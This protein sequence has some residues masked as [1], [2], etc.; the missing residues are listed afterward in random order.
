MSN[1]NYI[2]DTPLPL[3]QNF[4]EL[5]EEGLGF[6]QSTSG[7]AW[8][9]FN[10]SDPG[11]TI[12]DQMCYAL[13]ELGYCNDFSISDILTRPDGKLQME[14][15][16]YLP[17]IILTTSALTANDY[18]KLLIDGV[19]GVDNAIIISSSKAYPFANYVYETYL[20]IN[21]VISTD[22]Y[23]DICNSAYYCLNKSRNLGEQFLKP[24]PLT[25]K[26]FT[27]R[28]RLNIKSE[29]LLNATL[30]QI[31]NAIQNYIFPGITQ[32][33][34]SALKEK[35]IATNS[36]FNGPRLKNGWIL[37]DELGKKTDTLSSAGLVAVFNSVS[38]VLSVTGLCFNEAA[39]E[40]QI[41]VSAT[42][43]IVIDLMASVLSCKLEIYCNG[44]QVSE[45]QNAL[46]DQTTKA[47]QL[48]TTIAYGAWN[49]SQ[50]GLPKGK[51]RDIETYYSIQ[52]T[53]PEIF[54]VGADSVDSNAT[55]FE[56]AQSRQLK[57][58]LALTD[59][60]LANQFSQ[61]GNVD[62]LF[63]F[64]NT[65]T[66]IP[67]QIKSFYSTAGNYGNTYEEYPV[68]FLS[69]SST[70]FYQSLYDI[71]HIK[72]LLKNAN[73]FDYS[74]EIESGKIEEQ[75][76]WNEYKL[77]PYNSYIWGLMCLM[78]DEDINTS[79]R[80]AILDH[81]LARHGESPMVVDSIINNSVYTGTAQK[82]QVI[83]KSLY[84][85]NLGLLSY[86]R[87]KTYNYFAA[88][89]IS[90]NIERVPEDYTERLL[91][92][93]ST[94]FVFNSQVIDYIE[95]LKEQ[96]FVSFSAL[97]L[98]LSLLF[99]LRITYRNFIADAFE[100]L[101]KSNETLDEVV[102]TVGKANLAWWMISERKGHVL[103]ETSLLLGL[104]NANGAQSEKNEFI[105]SAAP[106]VIPDL[107]LIFPDFIPACNTA[108]FKYRLNLFIEECV[109]ANLN[110][111]TWHMS[112]VE[113]ALFI[114][115]YA[116]WHNDLTYKSQ[117]ESSVQ[118]HSGLRKSIIE[119]INGTD[120]AN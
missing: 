113:L 66:G 57:G 37:S 44:V 53:F 111:K 79:R 86:Y 29:T 20:L 15:Q 40:K 6:I 119:F 78:E 28:G 43:I 23:D 116:A 47:N 82:D 90:E 24:I 11:V 2:L 74:Y 118:S 16:F 103:I 21:K 26:I 38:N 10:Q 7:V 96:D 60:V 68:P 46:S 120:A 92:G 100:K 108:E 110:C 33:G 17:E 102:E 36:I 80:N 64:K 62:K 70:Y 95:K 77:D 101:N 45:I 59:Q 107:I 89:K 83:F 115:L 76:D 35:G 34:Y 56:I 50:A 112:S 58:Y 41:Q 117:A 8:T 97:E 19:E 105:V 18:S 27:L 61:L 81:L 71:P 65:L 12:L 99:G 63:S 39:N 31:Q 5:K 85:Q 94:D 93:A 88:F 55:D 9:N 98:K 32:A 1:A 67:S 13:T 106:P 69:F 87:Q 30:V 109:S 114:P 72:P 84:L 4:K 48:F 54:G 75:N 91:G 73:L 104:I 3:N 49:E 25:S 22:S 14:D 42:D 52:N 51:F